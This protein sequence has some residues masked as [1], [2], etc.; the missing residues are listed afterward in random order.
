MRIPYILMALWL[1]APV[2][3]LSQPSAEKVALAEELVR[4]LRVEKSL[5]AY[6]EQ[7]AKP[8]D[9]PF[10][11][12]VAFRSEPGS[13]G[14]ISPQS[15]YWPEVKAAYLKFQV[16]AC[17]YA[18]P[19]KMTRHY[20]EKLANDVSV[21]DLRAVI[22]FNRAGPGSRVQDVILVANASFQPYASKL[23]YEAY[24]VATKDFQQQIREIVRKY[25]REPK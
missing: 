10:D 18:T 7:C 16:T 17:A 14:G 8:E 4:L 11:P 15:S 6:L 23:M 3:A 21:D 13:F 24:E 19:E 2:A 20:V 22:E 25:R 5:A 9:S 1:L 12:M